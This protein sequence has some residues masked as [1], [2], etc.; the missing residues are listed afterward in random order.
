[1]AGTNRRDDGFRLAEAQRARADKAE[2]RV[3]ELRRELG[4]AKLQAAHWRGT[5]EL[6]R[7]NADDL[8]AL[9]VYHR[10]QAAQPLRVIAWRR[11]SAWL[12]GLCR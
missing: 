6:Q 1:M 9:L 10:A 11:L 3:A 12:E 5:C 2:R 7:R 8:Q 4:A